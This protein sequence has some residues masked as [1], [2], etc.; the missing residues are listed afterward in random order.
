MP[1]K[2]NKLC[3]FIAVFAF[4]GLL[5]L[6]VENAR[7]LAVETIACQS[8]WNFMDGILRALTDAGHHV[9]VFTPFPGGHRTNYT[10]V[11]TSQEFP[12][13]KGGNLMVLLEKRSH[14]FSFLNIITAWSR[15][16]CDIVYANGRLREIVGDNSKN[17]FDVIIVEPNTLDCMSYLANALGLP[18]IYAIPTPI[19]S[20]TERTFTGHV[21]NPACVSNLLARQAVPNT[22]VQ[23]LTNTAILAYGMFVSK[24]DELLL[25]KTDPKSYVLT[26]T[27]HPSMIF[28]NSHYVTDAPRSLPQNLIDVGGIHLKAPKSIPK[29]SDEFFK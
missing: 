17:D 29:V 24:F 6:P 8:H 12:L 20:Y 28:Q 26:P 5:I 2:W 22:F 19:I 23:R 21:P 10:E 1:G 16:L 11:D 13:V 25:Q 15:N 3:I 18:I 4:D 9:T 7:I 27:V 14:P